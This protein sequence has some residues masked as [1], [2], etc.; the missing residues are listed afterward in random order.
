[1][2]VAQWSE[3]ISPCSWTL[4]SFGELYEADGVKMSVVP[5]I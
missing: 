1:M 5:E 3:L 4:F 2:V